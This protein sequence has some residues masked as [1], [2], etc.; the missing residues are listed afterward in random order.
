M[1]RAAQFRDGERVDSSTGIAERLDAVK[2]DRSRCRRAETTA[3]RRAATAAARPM[4][5]L[6]CAIYFDF[7]KAFDSVVHS[8]LQIKL[9]GYGFGGTLHCILSDFFRNRVQRVVL[10]EGVSFYGFITSGV[11]QGSV[12][13]PLLFFTLHQ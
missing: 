5:A 13:G 8:K 6:A 7:S 9:Q 2:C 10:A 12:L 3:A 1:E 11:P 4:W